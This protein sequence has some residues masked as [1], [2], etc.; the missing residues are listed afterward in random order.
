MDIFG[1]YLKGFGNLYSE[2]SASDDLEKELDGVQDDISNKDDGSEK[3]TPEKNEKKDTRETI[4]PEPNPEDVEEDVEPKED[5]NKKENDQNATTED[6]EENPDGE[7][8]D[9]ENT[10]GESAEG[11]NPEGENT[12]GESTDDMSEDEYFAQEYGDA[13][14]AG[15]TIDDLDPEIK[16]RAHLRINTQFKIMFNKYTDLHTK[17]SIID[18]KEDIK[19]A[20]EP[21][22]NE[23]SQLNH[24]LKTYVSTNSDPIPIKIKRYTDIRVLYAIQNKNLALAL[25]YDFMDHIKKNMNTNKRRLW[26]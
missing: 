20:V 10:D 21:I 4:E 24:L 11:E 23:Y 9:G 26:D 6:G 19:R 16:R 14:A 5:K 25:G 15:N 8:P 12:D 13:E 17:V 22:L 3:S 2:N 18:L 7:N 1:E